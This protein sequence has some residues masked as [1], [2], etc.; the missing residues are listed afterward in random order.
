V[1]ISVDFD[2]LYI[3]LTKSETRA[4]NILLSGINAPG[5]SRVRR[6]CGCLKTDLTT[7]CARANAGGPFSLFQSLVT[8]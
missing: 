8:H 7:T 6:G 5:R 3:I 2:E 1:T 4:T